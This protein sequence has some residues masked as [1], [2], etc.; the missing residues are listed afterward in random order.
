MRGDWVAEWMESLN[1]L[2]AR[3]AAI[4]D[5]FETM[6]PNVHHM[7]SGTKHIRVKEIG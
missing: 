7:A 2:K 3:L 4:V 1:Q 6:E 5:T